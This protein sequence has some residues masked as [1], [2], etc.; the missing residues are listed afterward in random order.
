MEKPVCCQTVNQ[1]GAEA[2]G[3]SKCCTIYVPLGF[4]LTEDSDTYRDFHD[5]HRHLDVCQMIMYLNFTVFSND[6]FLFFGKSSFFSGV[7]LEKKMGPK[8]GSHI[9]LSHAL[10]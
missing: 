2:L 5:F 3:L 10:D 4:E 6:L 1:I 9:N 7:L 8:S